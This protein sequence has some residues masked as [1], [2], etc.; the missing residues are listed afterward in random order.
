MPYQLQSAV[1]KG[2]RNFIWTVFFV[3]VVPLVFYTV[4]SGLVVGEIELPGGFRF[5]FR[6]RR[7]GG[8][9]DTAKEELDDLSE[10]ELEQRQAELEQRF[11]ELEQQTNQPEIP[12]APQGVDLNGIWYSQNGLSY[13]IVQNGNF[14]T[15]QEINPLY[16][17]T[18][19]G[20]GQVQNQTIQ[21]TY[22]TAAYQQGSA[23][24]TISS[25]GRSL[26]GTFRDAYTGFTVP[27]NL[28]R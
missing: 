18:A 16:G 10:A 27:A 15:I 11:Q 26:T 28:Y 9:T 24:L 21:I 4:Y 17:V 23:N 5:V 22:Q 19:V 20:Q 8:T 13:Q 3:L 6:E 25:D 12:Q 14:I 2:S 1:M 7:I